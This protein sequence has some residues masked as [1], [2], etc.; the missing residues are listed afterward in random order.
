MTLR[1]LHT[2]HPLWTP[3]TVGRGEYVVARPPALASW[4]GRRARG[5]GEAG[6][7]RLE[8]V[9]LG[10]LI[11]LLTLLPIQA[12]LWMHGRNL[13][14]A[15]AASAAQS[16]ATTSTDPQ[17]RGTDAARA[18][19]AGTAARVDEVTITRDGDVA[20][21]HVT[22]SMASL[23]PGVPLHFTVTSQVPV[24]RFVADPDGT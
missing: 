12:G 22:I 16:A 2:R 15:A 11:V 10:G 18:M 20:T 1:R 8:L 5:S 23:V 19:L 9:L 3:R 7:A 21:A 17:G 14:T 6:G 4:R 24:D 13:A